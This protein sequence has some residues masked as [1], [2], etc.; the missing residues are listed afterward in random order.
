MKKDFNIEW[1]NTNNLPD[2]KIICCNCGKDVMLNYGYTSNFRNTQAIYI[3]HHCNAPNIIVNTEPYI[4]PLQGK[5]IKNLPE[6]IQKVYDEI[7][8]C[9]QAGCFTAGVMMMR[10]MLMSLAVT[11]G[12]EEGK[13][14]TEYVDYIDQNGISPI[15]MKPLV[16]KI[17]KRGNYPNHYMGLSSSEEADE[18]LKYIEIILLTNYE[19]VD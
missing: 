14:F 12:A 8:Q 18:L 13:P 11:S 6:N 19:F 15:K 9:L 5:D 1:V 2:K 3:C 16:D 17:R 4:L 10:K 7:R